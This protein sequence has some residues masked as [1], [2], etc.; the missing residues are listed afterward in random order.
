MIKI[1]FK[2]TI[3]YINICKYVYYNVVLMYW[4][5]VVCI[6]CVVCVCTI[7]PTM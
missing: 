1:Y 3:V 6:L 7:V 4:R 5:I 2:I